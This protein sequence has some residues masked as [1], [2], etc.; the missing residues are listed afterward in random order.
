MIYPRLLC[1]RAP[2]ILVEAW[3]GVTS[4]GA[5]DHHFSSVHVFPLASWDSV[6]FPRRDLLAMVL[7]ATPRS[8]SHLSSIDSYI[9]LAPLLAQIDIGGVPGARVLRTPDTA[10]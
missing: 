4:N 1:R 7:A 8:F 2:L 6:H 3:N 9:T 5:A 10:T